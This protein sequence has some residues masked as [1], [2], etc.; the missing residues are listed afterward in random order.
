MSLLLDIDGTLLDIAATPDAVCVPGTLIEA[1]HRLDRHLGGAVAF[2]SG[3]SLSMIDELFSPLALAAIGCHGAEMR[4]PGVARLATTPPLPDAVRRAVEE[5]VRGVPGVVVEDKLYALAIHYRQAP[6]IRSALGE[7]LAE[8]KP[9]LAA[10]N[11]EILAGKFVIEVKPRG[12]TKGTG[13]RRMLATAPFVQRRPLFIGDDTTDEDAFRQ[14]PDFHGIGFSVGRQIDGAAYVFD[15][16]RD[17][18][19][20]LVQLADGT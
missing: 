4:L 9:F 2:V 14:L 6:E 8:R 7:G 15:S 5:V 19:A 20:W 12:I 17:V 3:R 1:I 11:L 10:H 18:R 16:P 13:V